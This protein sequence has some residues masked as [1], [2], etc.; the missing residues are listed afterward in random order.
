MADIFLHLVFARRLRL[1]HGLHPL[2][3]ESL[4]RRPSLVALGATLPMLPGVE[5]KGMSFFRRLFSGGSEA[6]R[7]QKQLQASATPRVELIAAALAGG[8]EFGPMARLSFALG[9][10]SHEIVASKLSGVLAQVSAGER[11]AVERAQTRLWLQSKSDVDFVS[12]LRAIADL[13][14]LDLH[15]RSFDHVDGALKVAFNTK[16]GRDA[17]ARWARGLMA[18]VGVA[19]EQGLPPS[20]GMADSSARTPHFEDANVVF[21]LKEAERWF[22]V[23][24][25]RLGEEAG[26]DEGL[27]SA[28]IRRAL[29]GGGSQLLGPDAPSPSAAVWTPWYNEVRRRTLERGKNDEPAFVEG[30]VAVKAVQ[31]SNAFTGVMKLSDLST[32]E[33]PPELHNPSFPPASSVPAPPVPA[34]TQEVSL[35]QIEAAF[36]RP[37]LPFDASGPVPVAPRSPAPVLSQSFDTPAMTQEI[38]MSQ[39]EAEAMAF[40]SASASARLTPE[41]PSLHA[42]GQGI[43]AVADD[44]PR[45]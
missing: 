36:Q 8:A 18:E 42:D 33:L 14:D 5:R 4:A 17:L 15:R 16:P 39:I 11:P 27:T 1:A 6:A 43:E 19:E 13:G 10:L 34:M 45:E 40:A 38:S 12:E 35:A 32:S 28:G 20:L 37:P 3:G 25:N 7:W 2:I 23:V 22:V 9:S 24:A 31:R 21:L 30:Q 41:T 29:T 26:R 44:P